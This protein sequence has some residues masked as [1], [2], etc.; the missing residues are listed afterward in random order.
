M[1]NG[2]EKIR[3][4]EQKIA[5]LEDRLA[6]LAE[7]QQRDVTALLGCEDIHD[8]HRKLL[9]AELEDAFQRI[10]NIELTLFPRLPAN[11]RH[12]NRVIGDQEP[13]A[14]NPLDFRDRSKKS[15]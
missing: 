14:Y 7:K 11:I 9:S 10:I 13:K 12:L 1:E 2:D 5:S 6:K 3:Q 15:R 8:K 4:L